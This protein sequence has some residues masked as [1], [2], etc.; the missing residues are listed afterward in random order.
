MA[1]TMASNER[2]WGTYVTDGSADSYNVSCKKVL[3]EAAGNA[4]KLGYTAGS[5]SQLG[6]PN[7]VKMRR[8]K[9]V[10]ASGVAHWIPVYAETATLWTT[11]GTD[12]VINV[13]GVDTTVTSTKYHRPEFLGRSISKAA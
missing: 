13:K 10:D 3:V 1:S 11:P 7:E 2:I 6:I 8:V 9:C 4:A 5:A 12:I